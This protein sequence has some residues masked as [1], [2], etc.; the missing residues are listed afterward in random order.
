MNFRSDQ[1]YAPWGKCDGS[2]PWDGNQQANGYP[3]L[4]QVGR[5][6]STLISGDTPSPVQWPQQLVE[7]TY[8]WNNTL[9]G[10]A[11]QMIT[12]TPSH[13][14]VGRDFFNNADPAIRPTRIRIRW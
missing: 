6:Q 7:P 13:I 4:D 14:V 2:S 10:Q 11:A 5:S 12:I 1:A 9:N 3:C 8:A